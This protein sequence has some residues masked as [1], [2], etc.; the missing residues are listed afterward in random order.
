MCLCLALFS[1]VCH[2][3][4]FEN[5]T[6]VAKKLRAGLGPTAILAINDCGQ[7]PPLC[8]IPPIHTSFLPPTLSSFL[9]HVLSAMVLSRSLSLFIALYLYL[10][11]SRSL[12]AMVRSHSLSVAL[13]V[14]LSLSR[15]LMIFCLLTQ[16][17]CAFSD[18]NLRSMV[19]FVP[20]PARIESVFPT[21]ARLSLKRA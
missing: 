10:L 8:P 11:H 1:V 3:V 12:T 20:T 14:Y 16:V 7:K 21:P 5:M 19:P 4:P 2:G 6:A 18:R 9:S 13:R 17:Q 15:S